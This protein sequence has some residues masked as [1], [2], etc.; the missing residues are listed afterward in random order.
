MFLAFVNIHVCT[1]RDQQGYIRAGLGQKA[2]HITFS[3]KM[4][5]HVQS[6]QDVLLPCRALVP[7]RMPDYHQFMMI[8]L[9]TVN[10]KTAVEDAYQLTEGASFC[11][12]DGCSCAP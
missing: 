5:G 4:A 11:M 1:R 10:Y 2:N 9:R 12:L 3:P 6:R 7:F 8:K